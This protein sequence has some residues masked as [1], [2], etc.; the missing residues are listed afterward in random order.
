MPGQSSYATGHCVRMGKAHIHG[1]FSLVT[2]P[3]VWV[4]MELCGFLDL[5][6]NAS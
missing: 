1:S 2:G 6:E 3:C 5:C 4:Y